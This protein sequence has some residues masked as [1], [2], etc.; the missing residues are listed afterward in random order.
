MVS[1]APP[2]LRFGN[3]KRSH[4]NC[5]VVVN[6]RAILFG[7]STVNC[8]MYNA[9]RQFVPVD[10]VVE[11]VLREGKLPNWPPILVV[12]DRLPTG[13]R[14]LRAVD[15]NRRLFVS[16][17]AWRRGCIRGV[18]VEICSHTDRRIE[19]R[20]WAPNFSEDGGHIVR[21]V[22]Q[23]SR[24]EAELLK[25]RDLQEDLDDFLRKAAS[26]KH[27]ADSYKELYKNYSCVD[28]LH[29]LTVDL[30]K[31]IGIPLSFFS[32]LQRELQQPCLLA[33]ELQRD[34]HGRG[35]VYDDDEASAEGPKPPSHPPPKA[36]ALHSKGKRSLDDAFG[37]SKED[38]DELEE[39]NV[40]ETIDERARVDVLRRAA[41]RLRFIRHPSAASRAYTPP[42][43]KAK[44]K[45][46]PQSQ[47]KVS[48]AKQTKEAPMDAE[49]TDPDEQETR[50][51]ASDVDEEEERESERVFE[52]GD[53]EVRLD[54]AASPPLACLTLQ[55]GVGTSVF[56]VSHDGASLFSDAAN[57]LY[58][59]GSIGDIEWIGDSADDFKTATKQP[60]RARIL[61]RALTAQGG[62]WAQAHHQF[63]GSAR[64][65]HLIALGVA[66]NT[67]SRERAAKVALALTCV[68][69][70]G[71]SSQ[72]SDF[73][74]LVVRAK[75]LMEKKHRKPALKA[76]KV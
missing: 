65:A 11:M 5:A 35:L 19:G 8:R 56:A 38:D 69:N 48:D 70:C 62:V 10:S 72:H 66:G 22:P 24:F 40:G 43:P 68:A 6:P 28:M 67:K 44:A 53:V 20:P 54:N 75:R 52:V 59:C 51:P 61:S 45:P 58:S 14:C 32:D 37:D 7:Q 3:F 18:R 41:T 36:K 27:T 64:A 76:S 39:S 71:D 34:V 50:K 21:S 25:Y 30:A 74:H 12:E 26:C 9:R 4:H 17:I 16:R 33:S 31:S 23:R 13:E 42:R 1:T 29:G 55:D 73:Q 47:A 57:I 2:Q 15:G 49:E 46:T 60:Q 63:Y